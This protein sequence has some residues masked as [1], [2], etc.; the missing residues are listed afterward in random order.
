MVAC[1]DQEVDRLSGGV[2]IVL[3]CP[4]ADRVFV[5]VA[6]VSV[7]VQHLSIYH[8]VFVHPTTLT[9]SLAI[10]PYTRLPNRIDPPVAD[11]LTKE[12]DSPVDGEARD[13]CCC[14]WDSFP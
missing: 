13:L 8:H 6:D 11:P 7:D 3:L 5:D 9:S 2:A 1:R 4:P 14:R 12:I 10:A